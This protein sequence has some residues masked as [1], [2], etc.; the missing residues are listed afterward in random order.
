VD[1]PHQKRP[2]KSQS[3]EKNTRS[4][5][6]DL[7]MEQVTSLPIMMAK[8]SNI[9]MSSFKEGRAGNFTTCSDTNIQNKHF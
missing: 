8:A 2:S 9:A 7:Q 1:I 4:C 6:L 5:N 3:Q